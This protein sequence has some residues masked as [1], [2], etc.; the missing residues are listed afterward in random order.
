MKNIFREST[1]AWHTWAW[2][3]LQTQKGQEQGVRVLLR[4]PH[5]AV[6]GGAGHGSE[7]GFVF[8]NLGGPGGGPSGLVGKLRPEDIAMS[9]S[10]QQLL[11]EFREGRRPE[12]RG[13]ARVAGV[14]FSY[15]AGD[16]L[17]RKAGGARCPISRS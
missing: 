5:P 3:N 16:D 1:F 15:A 7:I 12:R 13:L 6:A 10:H 4:S 8:R 2:A 17:R 9:G 11:G 14:C